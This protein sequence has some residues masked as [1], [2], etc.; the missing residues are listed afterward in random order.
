METPHLHLPRESLPAD[1]AGDG[2]TENSIIIGSKIRL[3]DK[4]LADAENDYTWRK[5][6][7]LAQLDAAPPLAISFSR[8]LSDYT[9]ELHYPFLTSRWFAV[10]TLDG[11]HI[12]NCSY[13]NINRTKGEA[14]LGIMIGDRDYWDKGYGAD[15]ITTLVS[16]IFQHKNFERVYLKTLDSNA[17]AQEC[18]RQCGFTPYGHMN[19]DGY[20][21]LLMELHRSRWQSRQTKQ[22]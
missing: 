13:Y 5:D 10:E 12:G 21:F 8:Y 2:T 11:K 17:R 19:K 14:E 22:D 9:D 3:R 7:E 6:P 4:K 18:F 15:T 1:N 20:R 16:H